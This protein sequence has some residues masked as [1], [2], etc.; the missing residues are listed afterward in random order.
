MH[1][2]TRWF[3]HN[4]VAANLI[5]MLILAAGLLSL[6][7]LRTEGLPKVPGQ[8][9][10]IRTVLPNATSAQV[11]ELVTQ[12]IEQQITSV[13]G[14][15]RVT[16]TS[17]PGISYITLRG[18]DGYDMDT[19]QKDVRQ[20]LDS[21]SD[22]PNDVERSNIRRRNLDL[23][24]LYLQVYGDADTATLQR[25]ARE[26]KKE[27]LSHRDISKLRIWGL[28]DENLV[29]EVSPDNLEKY[30]LDM[31]DIIRRVEATDASLQSGRITTSTRTFDIQTTSRIDD[32]RPLMQLPI[33]ENSSDNTKNNT[34]D[35]T[36]IVRLS[37]VATMSYQPKDRDFEARFD[38]KKSIGMVIRVANNEGVFK[39]TKAVD[40]VI[41][42]FQPPS[43]VSITRWGEA[44]EYIEKR[45]DL[46]QTNALQGLLLVIIILSLFLNARLAFWVAMGIPICIAGTLA[47]MGLESVDYS[48]NDITTFGFI[49]VLG[50]LVDDAVVIG[51]SVHEHQKDTGDRLEQTARGVNKVAVATIFGVL[52]TIAALCAMLFIENEIGKILASFSGVMIIAL[53][54]SLFE[55]KFILP[56]HLAHTRTSTNNHSYFITRAWHSCQQAC[57]NGLDYARDRWYQPVLSVSLSNRYA[58]L[59]V[60]ISIA[61]LGFALVKHNVIKTSFFPNIP[62]QVIAIELALDKEA[63]KALIQRYSKKI[64]RTAKD[65][66]DELMAKLQLPSAPIQH[67]LMIIEDTHFAEIYVELSAAEERTPFNLTTK[68]ITELWQKKVGELESVEYLTFGDS[69]NLAGGLSVSLTS[70][71]LPSLKA[72][73]EE[74]KQYLSAINGVSDVWDSQQRGERE[75]NITLKPSAR[76]LGFSDQHIAKQVGYLFGSTKARRIQYDQQAVDVVVQTPLSTRDSLDKFS[77]ARIANREGAWFPLSQIAHISM[78]Y[79]QTEIKRQSG[80]LNININAN[81]LGSVT[82]SDDINQRI[83]Q[84]LLPQLAANYPNVTASLTGD[85]QQQD[86]LQSE[87]MSIFMMIC[88]AIFVLLAIPLKSYWQPFVILSVLPFGLFGALIGHGIMGLELSILSF[89]GL[90]ALAG[91]IVNDCLV[92]VSRF[93]Q[94]RSDTLPIKTALLQT[95]T[96]R[97]QAV[98]LT[99]VTTVAGLIPLMQETSEQAQYL[100]PAAVSL[101]FGELFATVLTLILVPVL[102]AVGHDIRQL[103][104]AITRW[105]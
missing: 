61:T 95:G 74:I 49:I 67:V 47:V 21:I 36:A 51:E 102:L 52:T 86:E 16:S 80:K 40:E 53:A 93:N 57:K 50:I 69:E 38:G 8:T 20:T 71:N 13:M 15:K 5:M 62:N 84:E 31:G 1:A 22:L 66:N 89:L 34:N 56:A 73:S 59:V 64:E 78:G 79:G 14:I 32:A 10:S 99:T 105:Q 19:L 55:S 44:S 90:L 70:N 7:N 87:L 68:D 83:E 104:Q 4:P 35:T 18:N 39:I 76:H 11:D 6:F 27:L 2:L 65:V 41:S 82:S 94:T 42:R 60:F 26:L 81:Y 54:F 58:V 43:N 30:H 96:G 23:P 33:K 25:T 46:L 17:M 28:L 48:I 88:L 72:A 91:I 97:F 3:I 101:A 9:L 37:D 29:I 100:I 85:K 103:K 92:L 98:F 63:P 75:I 77:Q 12:V 45:L 24:A